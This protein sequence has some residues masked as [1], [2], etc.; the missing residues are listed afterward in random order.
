MSLFSRLWARFRGRMRK[1][2]LDE[3]LQFHLSMREQWNIDRGM[4][5]T[6]ARRNARLR[7]GNPITWRE[8]MR[9]LD[10]TTL[11]RTLLQDVRYGCRTLTHNARFTVVA[12]FALALGIGINT[13]TFTA[14]KGLFR[15]GVDARDAA[16]IVDVIMQLR[17]GQREPLFSYPDFQAYRQRAHAFSGLIAQSHEFEQLILSDAGGTLEDRKAASDSL[18]AKWGLLPSAT[19]A[20]KAEVAS[21]FMVSE[22]YFA[23]LGVTPLRGR[24]FAEGDEARL[25]AVPAVLISE[26]Y[27]QKRFAGDPEIVGRAVRLNGA[28]VVIIGV[29]PHDFVGT[30]L[31]VPDFWIPMSVEPL[32]HQGDRSLRDEEDRSCRVFGRLAAGVSIDQAQAELSAIAMQQFHAHRNQNEKDPPQSIHL[33][34]GSPFPRELDSGLLFAIFLIMAAT[35]MVLVI[36][37]ANVAALQLAR[38]TARQNE[39]RVRVSLGASRGRL[40]RQL[41][42]ESALLGL[43]AGAAALFCSWVM[44][45]ILA[46]LAKDTLPT[47]MG[48]F[49][50][51]VNPDMQVFLYV[52]VIS[53]LA[54]VLFGL[55]PAMEST[56]SALSSS[57]KANSVMSPARS[58]RLRDW[59]IGAQVALCFVLLIAGSMMVRSAIHALTMDTG[60]DTR[61]VIG[62]SLQFPEGPEYDSARQSILIDQI[63]DRLA[64]TPGVAAVASGRPPDGG[65]LRTA[66]VSVDGQKPD[67]HRIGAYVFYTFVDANYFDTL[68]IRIV[69][70]HGF[71]SQAGTPEPVVVLSEK[72]AA[73]LWPGKSPIGRSLRMS[74]DGQ[75]H[76]KHELLPDG[77]SYQVIGIAHDVRGA[78]LDNSDAAQIYVPLPR[79][80]RKNYPLL[81]RAAIPP[82]QLIRD[83]SSAIAAA[84]PNVVASA[85]TLDEMLRQTPPFMV[86]SIVALIA[87]TV[88]LLGLVLAAMGIYGTVSY[89]VVQRTREVG[90]RM[91][92]GARKGD[93]LS[94]MLRDGSKPVVLGLLAGLALAMGDSYVLRGVLYGIGRVDV[95]S[96]LM[97]SALF[98]FIAFLASCIPARRA[99]QVEPAESLRCE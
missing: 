24:F 52:L 16:N 21:V 6:Q 2:E 15:R 77:P 64:S 37:C 70:G 89:M 76:E 25:A 43:V 78:L 62:L 27:W 67:P 85:Y 88:G 71:N 72:A 54:G 94:L 28:A 61:H 13:T 36:A 14:Y 84:D 96:F 53:L 42:T 45:R 65:G 46:R 57:L 26:N 40:V 60:Y 91:A 41:L 9:A 50:V 18:F 34:P 44:L 73:Q 86:S 69:Y 35:A 29:T 4:P 5:Q 59:L 30:T 58:R 1:D 31:G 23:V 55:A 12:V 74:T 99:M 32:I 68:G 79:E 63:A 7:F 38:A 20:S 82:G 10:W 95:V 81:V 47:N 51:H 97:V 17:L 3:E 75:Y 83:L 98:L 19:L 87:G 56:R 39:L 66:G 49:V 48:T 22:N 80:H 8:Q 33:M 93:V 11:P 92:M 90:I